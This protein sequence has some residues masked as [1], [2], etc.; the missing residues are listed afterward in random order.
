MSDPDVAQARRA[1]LQT[2]VDGVL[3]LMVVLLV[4][5]MWLLSAT[6]DVFLAGRQA[7]ALPAAIASAV[8]FAAC[9]A[10][11]AFVHRLDRDR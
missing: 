6:L 4:T 3:A 10:L 9:A 1:R 7:A 2:A 8:L 5:Q 11:L